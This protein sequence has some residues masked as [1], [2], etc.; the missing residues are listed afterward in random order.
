[1]EKA[2][3]LRNVLRVTKAQP[4]KGKDF[5]NFF[6][7][8]DEAR[9]VNSAL[10]LSDIFQINIDDPQKVLFMGH[11]GSGK[12]TELYRF[13]K[14]IEDEFKVVNFSVKDEIDIVDLEYT[15]LI[16]VILRK[17][18]EEAEKDKIPVNEYV[19]DNLDHYWHDKKLIDELKIEK[20]KIE[21]GGKIKGGLFN[22]IGFYISGVLSTGSESK[23]AVRRHIKPRLSQLLAGGNDLIADISRKYKKKGKT[24]ILVIEDLDKLEIPV[25]KKLFLDH[26]NI[27]T[28][29]NLHIV[30][31]FP[32]FLHY[33]GDFDEIGSVFDHYELLSMI[34][35][36]DINDKSYKKGVNII[37]DIVE[38][39]AELSLFEPEALEYVIEKSGGSL[40]HV[41]EMLQNAVLD[42]RTRDRSAE[43]MDQSSA[44]MAYKRLRN[45]F[46]RIIWAE[47]MIPLKA[48][49]ES[50]D[51]KPVPDS[52]LNELLKCMAVIEYN[53]ERWC[54]IHP[55]V[56]DILKKKGEIGNTIKEC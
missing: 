1:M 9:G 40:R 11:R 23:V 19:L 44:E 56:E 16:F 50:I 28:S 27:L 10:R 12:S 17:L 21:T 5:D 14:Y 55:A 31:T 46:E 24:L 4:L 18:F 35:V 15:D 34:K 51:K 7:E 38:K 39:R 29:F 43:K 49:Y 8:T 20:A 30:Y 25:A 6:V 32:I 41:F 22:V 52:K 26:K 47:H 37:R 13:G 42:A 3:E 2:T 33:S 48:L 36:K 53:G 54:G 45:Y